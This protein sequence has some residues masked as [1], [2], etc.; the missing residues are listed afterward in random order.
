MT[1]DV[2]GIHHITAIASDPRRTA[3]FYQKLLGLRLIKRTVNF[4]DPETY[5][6]YFGDHRGTPGT[7]LTFFPYPH[8]APGRFGAGQA[9]EITFA[10]PR[11][12][13]SQWIDRLVVQA[14]AFEG[15][16]VRF[17]ETIIRCKDPDGLVIELVAT[18]IGASER[19]AAI[20]A[21]PDIPADIPA[22]MAIRGLHAV[23]LWV[24]DGTET[25]GILIDHLG[26]AAAGHDGERRR[27]VAGRSG[28]GQIVD[29][30]SI[31]GLLPGKSGAGTVH[32]VAFRAA[33]AAQQAG[34]RASLKGARIGVTAVIDRTYFQSIYFREPGGVLFE[35]ATDTPG[36]TIDE[37]L[38][39]LGTRLMLPQQHEPK[40]ATIE[41]RLPK[42]DD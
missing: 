28:I 6:L 8:A 2:S 36:F 32:H 12:A 25:A 5:H 34:I 40:R 15:P 17:G 41:A 27:Y 26:F 35:V 13:L 18:D 14:K 23:T 4:D 39:A 7:I 30:R 10:I 1:A 16:E 37:P 31:P 11:A 29:L 22:D 42:L 20:L 24:E 38:A 33:D 9:V 3:A 21:P 19:A